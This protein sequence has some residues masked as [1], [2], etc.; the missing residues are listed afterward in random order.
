MRLLLK[1]SYRKFHFDCL[2]AP[3][4]RSEKPMGGP[5]DPPPP[6]LDIRGLIYAL[7]IS[8]MAGFH[9]GEFGRATKRWAVR[10]CTV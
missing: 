2:K 7:N 6:P 9:F 1:Y 8:I 10:E 5:F 4:F 3:N